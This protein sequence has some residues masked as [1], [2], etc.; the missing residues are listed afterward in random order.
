MVNLTNT[1]IQPNPKDAQKK[2]PFSQ[3]NQI[4]KWGGGVVECSTRKTWDNSEHSHEKNFVLRFF[5]I[6]IYNILDLIVFF[7]CLMKVSRHY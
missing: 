2:L 6:Y 1:E 7:R 3:S 4:K 5:R